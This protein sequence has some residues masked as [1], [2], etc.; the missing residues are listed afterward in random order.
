LQRKIRFHIQL[1]PYWLKWQIK[2][3]T[4]GEGLW[5][6]RMSPRHVESLPHC[7]IRFGT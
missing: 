3:S 6:F 2:R 5:N 1:H 4:D 7:R